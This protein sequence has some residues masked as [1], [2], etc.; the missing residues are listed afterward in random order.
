MKVLERKSQTDNAYIRAE[1]AET[2]VQ[3][4]AA[5]SAEATSNP[6]LSW[7]NCET[8]ETH[9]TDTQ[10]ENQIENP[11]FCESTEPKLS[12]VSHPFDSFAIL[13]SRSVPEAG[14]NLEH[15]SS[16]IENGDRVC[17]NRT[18]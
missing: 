17:E 15:W 13:A 16:P 1:L 4:P 12:Q 9:R 8:S 5:R 14:L 10:G 2:P 11:R 6:V 3:P 7:K 18:R